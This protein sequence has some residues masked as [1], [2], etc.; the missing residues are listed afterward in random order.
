[1]IR[2]KQLNEAADK[3]IVVPFKTDKDKFEE[4][5]KLE[6]D[7]CLNS[8]YIA[9][10]R[11]IFIMGN[12]GMIESKVVKNFCIS[13]ANVMSNEKV[14]LAGCQDSAYK[15]NFEFTTNGNLKIK[16][17]TSTKCVGILTDG[18]NQVDV[19]GTVVEKSSTKQLASGLG[20]PLAGLGSPSLSF[21]PFPWQGEKRREKDI[22][23]VNFG[24]NLYPIKKILI[25]FSEQAEAFEVVG[26][27]RFQE[28]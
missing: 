3:C 8:L 26:T 12:D 7:T 2:S 23:T 6:V 28:T 10:G 15:N 4:K 1:M 14:I 25:E 13:V 27:N 22:I 24:E 16:Q 9:D 5:Q 21:G 18:Y 19:D 17:A 11:E 20:N